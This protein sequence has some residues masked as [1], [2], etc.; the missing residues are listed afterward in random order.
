MQE[1]ILYR[2]LQN[3]SRGEPYSLRP[4]SSPNSQNPLDEK[5]R[6]PVPLTFSSNWFW[7]GGEERGRE[8]YAI[9][10]LPWQLYP[11]QKYKRNM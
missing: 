6:G 4:F 10:I 9:E 8:K 7:E 11:E 2:L 3:K 1:N 5:A